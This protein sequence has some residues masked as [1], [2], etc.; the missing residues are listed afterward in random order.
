MQVATE[1]GTMSPFRPLVTQHM[2]AYAFGLVKA[3]T[4][5]PH[6]SHH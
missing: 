3:V 5:L 2:Q 1:A 6:K 4:C